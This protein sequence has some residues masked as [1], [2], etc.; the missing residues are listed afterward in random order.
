MEKRHSQR[1][2]KNLKVTFPC[3]NKLYSGTVTDLSESGMLIYSE[4]NLPIKSTFE[5]LISINNEIIKLPAVFV[6]LEKE[7]NNYKGMGVKLLNPPKKYV[8]Y[9]HALNLD[10]NTFKFVSD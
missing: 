4:V 7:G 5:V 9:V 6:R 3:C 8:E 10:N 2:P 1:I